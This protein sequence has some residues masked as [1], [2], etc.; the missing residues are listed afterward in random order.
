MNSDAPFTPSEFVAGFNQLIEYNLP[1]V[2]IEGEVLEFRVSK[3]RWIYFNIADSQSSVACFGTFFQ[4]KSPIEEGMMIRLIAVP[5]LH[6][7]FGFSLNVLSIMPVG[8]GA[9]KRS[10]EILKAKLT[11]EGLFDPERKRNLPFAP[12]RVG[13]ITSENSAA[14]HD[15]IKI[16]NERWAGTEVLLSDVL[17][18]G[19]KSVASIVGAIKAQNE[20]PRPPEVIV[21]TRGGGSAEDLMAFNDEQVVRAVAGSRV[22]TLVAIGHEVD[23]SLAELTADVRASTPSNAVSLLVPDK[24]NEQQK[25]SVLLRQLKQNLE[26]S[27]IIE[28]SALVQA[29]KDLFSST[30]NLLTQMLSE[31][32]QY[33]MLVMAL[34]P[35]NVLKRGYS[36]L[37][38]DQ[39]TIKSIKAVDVGQDITNVVSDGKIISTVKSL[40][41]K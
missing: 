16:L 15:F 29:R 40:K 9:L 8:E 11:A 31:L 33:K 10:A 2:V 38:S 14:Y 3:N 5:R 37:L 34:N 7:K 28:Q 26:D 13:L 17:V 20:S 23:I 22:P 39:G 25:L 30:T 35:T 18:Q 4:I 12:Q 32:K 21:I 6:N 1:S 24:I 36:I 27:L 41:L 19:E